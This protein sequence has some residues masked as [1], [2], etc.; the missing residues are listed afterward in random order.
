[1]VWLAEKLSDGG[2]AY[3][4][5]L[6]LLFPAPV[7]EYALT[8]AVDGLRDRHR[9]LRSTFHAVADGVEQRVTDLGPL[10]LLVVTVPPDANTDAEVTR[11]FRSLV[12]RPSTSRTSHRY[13]SPSPLGMD[14][15]NEYCW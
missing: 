10:P 2:A 7:D 9:I 14:I 8:R 6:E 11:A 1:M 15:V 3:G 12:A 13:G 4:G 5:G